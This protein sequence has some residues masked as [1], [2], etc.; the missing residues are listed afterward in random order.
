MCRFGET[1]G[2]ARTKLNFRLPFRLTHLRVVWQKTYV[3]L[4]HSRS[5]LYG[6]EPVMG[7]T[8]LMKLPATRQTPYQ[9]CKHATSR[10]CSTRLRLK[11]ASFQITLEFLAI[12]GLAI[13][14]AYIQAIIPQGLILFIL[15]EYMPL[16]TVLPPRTAVN[17][18]SLSPSLA[19]P[20]LQQKISS[21]AH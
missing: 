16:G 14:S 9:T 8:N 12:I 6:S 20:P 18:H 1:T 4:L 2:I 11:S 17:S 7:L 19:R 10:V 21:R 3:Q 13:Q 15:K 5:V